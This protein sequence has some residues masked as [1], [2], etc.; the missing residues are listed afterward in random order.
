MVRTSHWGQKKKSLLHTTHNCTV[1]LV[2]QGAAVLATEEGGRVF[3]VRQD[4]CRVASEPLE[5]PE[6]W[7]FRNYIPHS[8]MDTVSEP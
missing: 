3:V 8:R 1:D 4:L 5:G 6:T 7:L 2:L